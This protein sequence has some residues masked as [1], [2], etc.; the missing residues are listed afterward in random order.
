MRTTSLILLGAVSL[1]A[2]PAIADSP[3]PTNCPKN[4]R[5]AVEAKLLPVLEA[6]TAAAKKN[7]WFDKH[8]EDEFEKLMKARDNDSKEARVALMDYYIGEHMG[9]EVVCAVALDGKDVVELLHL[10]DRCDIRPV[11]SSVPRVRTFPLR[12][13]AMEMIEK[14][15]AKHDCDY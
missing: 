4:L 13:F 5:P 11:R 8:Y 15:N 7:D 3:P 6:L 12:A 9:E 10:Y 14:G 1:L 2:S